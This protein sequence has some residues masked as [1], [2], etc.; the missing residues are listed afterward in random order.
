[1]KFVLG[2]IK[3]CEFTDIRVKVLGKGE[4][5]IRLGVHQGNKFEIVVRDVDFKPEAISSFVNYFGEQRFSKN[6]AEIGKLLV[7]RD[8]KK[9][10]SLINQVEVGEYLDSHPGDY[11]GALRKLPLRLLKMYVHSYQSLLW[12][13]GVKLFVESGNEGEFPLYGFG[14]ELEDVEI[15]DR[16][17]SDEGISQRDFVF[18]EIPEISAEGG[19]RQAVA[20]VYDLEIGELEDDADSKKILVKFRLDKGCYATEFIK[21][22]FN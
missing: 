11:I 8:F 13:R 2:E 4:E 21:Q 22:L 9:A 14:T 19:F 17:I 16:I 12:N 10:C 5:A 1:M 7:K 3:D 18:K 20:Q 6:N 15:M